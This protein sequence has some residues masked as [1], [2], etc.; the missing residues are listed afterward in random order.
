MGE[1]IVKFR[2]KRKAAFAGLIVAAIALSGCGGENAQTVSA[3]PN[4]ALGA[5]G[6]GNAKPDAVDNST[7]NPLPGQVAGTIT[8]YSVPTASSQPWGV[9]V[10]AGGT[11]WVAEYAGSNIASFV[12]STQT[13]TTYATLTKNAQP[14]DV[15]IGPDGNPWYIGFTSDHIG[16]V[17]GGVVAEYKLPVSDP[18]G[19]TVAPAA[20]PNPG[21]WVALNGNGGT[22]AIDN[23]STSGT[24][25]DITEAASE[26]PVGISADSNG[27]IGD[28]RR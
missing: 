23:V 25:T 4:S 14:R 15:V 18:E 26:A 6:R 12:P 24:S 7:C 1:F 8:E 28:L 10:D 9:A 2:V 27:N 5:S 11:V 16:T 21:M 20:E 19:I 17:S 3:L 13:W 22:G